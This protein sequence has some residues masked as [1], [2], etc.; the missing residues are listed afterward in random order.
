M[1][2]TLENIKIKLLKLSWKYP[3]V[4]IFSLGVLTGLLLAFIF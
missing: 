4:T 3:R 1:N 2:K